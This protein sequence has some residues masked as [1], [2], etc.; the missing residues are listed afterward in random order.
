M[1]PAADRLAELLDKIKLQPPCI[2]VICNVNSQILPNDDIASRLREQIVQPVRW[3]Q[4]VDYCI[5][6]H[7]T[8]FLEL[9]YGS[10]LTG[11][12]QQHTKLATCL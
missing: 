1:Q 2:P 4:S 9:G 7:A 5:E 12:M 8:K 6:H 3:S 11:L 10:V